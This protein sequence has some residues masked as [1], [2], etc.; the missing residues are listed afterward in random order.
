MSELQE[1]FSRIKENQKKHKD[2]KSAYRD[3]LVNSE[4]YRHVIEE[5]KVLKDKKRNLEAQVKKDFGSEFDQ[6]ETTKHDLATDKELLSDLA[7]TK[8]MKGETVSVTDE[9]EN[10]YEPIFSVKFKKT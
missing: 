4:Q 2:I 1:I 3:A 5:L 10:E 7:I 9:Y 8:L 6:L